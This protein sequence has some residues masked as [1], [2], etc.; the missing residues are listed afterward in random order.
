MRGHLDI[1]GLEPAASRSEPWFDLNGRGSAIFRVL[2]RVLSTQ[3]VEHD[4]LIPAGAQQGQK[5]TPQQ[6]HLGEWL[7][8]FGSAY[9]QTISDGQGWQCRTCSVE[10]ACGLSLDRDHNA[11]IHILYRALAANRSDGSVQPHVA[12]GS[13]C[14][15]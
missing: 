14:V 13:S 9:F 5:P 10:C 7:R 12:G 8:T 3:L 4:D 6:E 2:T 11:A 1:N 15:L